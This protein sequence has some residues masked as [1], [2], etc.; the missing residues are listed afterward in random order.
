[1]HGANSY[2]IALFRA[3]IKGKLFYYATKSTT[4][5]NSSTTSE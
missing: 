5:T 1:M 4:P 2:T 3:I